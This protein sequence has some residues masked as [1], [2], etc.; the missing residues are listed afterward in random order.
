LF[1]EGRHDIEFMRQLSQ[2]LAR[3]HA[4]PTDLAALSA[5]GEV[6]SVP[7]GGGA[8]GDWWN[9]FSALGCPEF[10]LLDR[11]QEPETSI[12]R[13]LVAELPQ[14]PRRQVR[15][16][17]KRSLE[18]YLHP[19]AIFAAGGGKVEFGD[20][21]QVAD[22]VVRNGLLSEPGKLPWSE[23]PRRTRQ[24]LINR[25]KR[26]LAREAVCQMSLELLTE[27]D[28]AG[29]VLSWFETIRALASSVRRS[30]E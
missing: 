13:S 16:T 17:S 3:Q 9:R 18:S 1:L 11:E 8:V 20:E 2:V 24:R 22:L 30:R 5:S 10:F 28:P 26:W 23:L 7:M 4:I 14:A 21:D 27:R 15:L 6:I 19:Q 12:R 29:E 25:A